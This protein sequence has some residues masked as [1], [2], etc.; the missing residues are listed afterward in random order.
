[1]VRHITRPT[2]EEDCDID[3]LHLRQ[4]S[5][6]CHPE[7]HQRPAPH[8]P[9]LRCG[10]LSP[11]GRGEL[12]A[13]TG[14]YQKVMG[15]LRV[16][17]RSVLQP[18]HATPRRSALRLGLRGSL[19]AGSACVGFVVRLAVTGATAPAT[20]CPAWLTTSREHVRRVCS[21]ARSERSERS[22]V[23]RSE[24]NGTSDLLIQPRR[25]GAAEA[26]KGPA[27]GVLRMTW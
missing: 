20:E 21:Q 2:K 17:A 5:S 8:P 18:A 15:R 12:R 6:P 9:P 1:M 22:A 7:K 16:S 27:V 26:G 24:R 14:L 3:S 13:P 19:R 4:G 11:K 23:N 10:D 25:R